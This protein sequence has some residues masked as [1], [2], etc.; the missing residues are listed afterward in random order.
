MSLAHVVRAT[1]ADIDA[2]VRLYRQ[3]R[4]VPGDVVAL[5]EDAFAGTC[6]RLRDLEALSQGRSVGVRTVQDVRVI[7]VTRGK[8][9]EL[10]LFVDPEQRLPR[11]GPGSRLEGA[12][13]WSGKTGDEAAVVCNEWRARIRNVDGACQRLI[14]ALKYVPRCLLRRISAMHVVSFP[15]R[16]HG[17][18]CEF[19]LTYA[20]AV[21]P[22]SNA[23]LL[24]N[25]V[26]VIIRS[27]RMPPSPFLTT[28]TISWP[29]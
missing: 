26:D 13:V 27:R 19:R 18:V 2:L 28:C 7:T 14:S 15:S 16:L 10:E 25:Q 20:G 22:S 3:L 4:G 29:R 11:S 9:L 8:L 21:P 5:F 12:A 24:P 17:M 23:P 1:L 6:L